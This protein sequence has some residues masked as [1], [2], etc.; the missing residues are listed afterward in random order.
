MSLRERLTLFI[1]VILILFS[2]NVGT[3][4]WSNSTRNESLLKLRQAVSGQLQSSVVRQNLDDL[5]KAILLLGSL[6]STLN[7]SLTLEEIAQALSEISALQAEIQQLSLSTDESTRTTY[8]AIEQG[9]LELVP[10]WKTFYRQYNNADYDHTEDR[11]YRELL[12]QQIVNDLDLLKQ[13]QVKLADRQSIEI[14]DIEYLTNLITFIV[15]VTSIILTIGLG[16]YLIRYTTEAFTELKEGT[17][18]IGGGDLDYR[19]PV[20]KKG[21]LGEVAQAFNA[22]SAKLQHAISEVRRA[23]E[24]ADLANQAKSSFLANMS[25]ELR[26]PLNAIIGYSEMLLEDIEIGEV[27]TG[28]QAKDLQKILTAGRHLL[29]QINDVLDFSKIETGKMTV[30]REEFD[31]AEILKE[32]ITTITPLAHK[33][34]NSLSF[35]CTGHLPLLNNDV[36]KFRQIFFNLLSNSCKFTQNGHINLSASYDDSLDP[37]VVRYEVSDNGIG[38]TEQQTN[39]VFDAF[40]QA[41]STTTRKYGGTGLGLAL[42]KQYCELM[43]GK[44]SVTSS[45]QKGT[46]FIVEFEVKPQK[47]LQSKSPKIFQ[48]RIDKTLPTI[49]VIDDD[50]VALALTERFLHRG[51]FNI[52]MVDN[53][54]D[55]IELAETELPD[56]ILLDLMMPKIDGWS[57]LSALKENTATQNIPVILLSMLDEQNLGLDMGALDYLRKPINWDKLSDILNQLTL[58][59]QDHE[60]IM[61]DKRSTHRDVLIN[62]LNR[63]GWTVHCGADIDQAMNQIDHHTPQAVIVSADCFSS[64]DKSDLAGFLMRAQGQIP[65]QSPIIVL[66]QEEMSVKRKPQSQTNIHY[67]LR[68]GFNTDAIFEVLDSVKPS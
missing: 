50:P 47:S 22:M 9:F 54:A 52:L 67:V 15:F 5:H 21:E 19:I 46:K 17:V 29:N 36:T 39:I 3:D 25:H 11:D 68:E 61:L 4:T 51:E 53:G 48:R 32:V 14:A 24:N 18:I 60:L 43:G 64:S 12:F 10:Q 62:R 37:P 40:I 45:V 6:R 38:M 2:I 28:D 55:G 56:I 66:T 49:L 33:G 31:S 41:D 20:G 16:F 57:V 63:T 59:Q 13:Q 8:K 35:N 34:N 44:I 42:C 26:T 65:S 27:D 1:T 58:P 30:Y 23:K 7:E